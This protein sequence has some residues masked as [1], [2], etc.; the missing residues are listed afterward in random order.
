MSETL[1]FDRSHPTCGNRISKYPIII[2]V[3]QRNMEVRFT[4]R[5]PRGSLAFGFASPLVRAFGASE[6]EKTS[7]TREFVV[8]P[9]KKH[10]SQQAT[11]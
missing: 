8:K 5:A 11:A 6:S 3:T 1:K 10:S 2:A 4:R 7:E 9:D